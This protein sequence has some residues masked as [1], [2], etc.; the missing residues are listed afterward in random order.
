MGFG[1]E[2]GQGKRE[3][4]AKMSGH[5]ARVTCTHGPRR[6]NCIHHGMCA[7]SAGCAA[8]E[9]AVVTVHGVILLSPEKPQ[10]AFFWKALPGTD[11][12]DRQDGQ[13]GR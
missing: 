6:H 12:G 5:E 7:H 10:D 1:N 13:R 2:K 9:S 4:E 11:R 8:L 3:G